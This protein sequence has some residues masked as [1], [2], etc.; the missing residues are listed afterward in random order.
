[1]VVASFQEKE[2]IAGLKVKILLSIFEILP[3]Q[4]ID[5]T[6]ATPEELQT[7]TFLKSI[8]RSMVKI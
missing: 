8:T 1:L 3:E 5:I 2:L 6:V 7:D 4:R